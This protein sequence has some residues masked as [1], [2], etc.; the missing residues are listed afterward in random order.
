MNINEAKDALRE[1]LAL[2]RE[3]IEMEEHYEKKAK[4]F[5]IPASA[6][7]ASSNIVATPET[8]HTLLSNRTDVYSRQDYA[9]KAIEEL[10]GKT[11][12]E[13]RT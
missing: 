9:N 10:L 1:I 12:A 7:L 8:L 4:S 11:P 13:V 6:I 3:Q 2:A 5:L